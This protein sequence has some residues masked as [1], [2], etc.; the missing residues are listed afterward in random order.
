MC[1]KRSS[2][3]QLELWL[4]RSCHSSLFPRF[5]RLSKPLVTRISIY[6]MPNQLIIGLLGTRRDPGLLTAT[7][8][9]DVGYEPGCRLTS[10]KANRVTAIVLARFLGA[11][12]LLPTLINP[13]HPRRSGRSNCRRVVLRSQISLVTCGWCDLITSSRY[14][15]ESGSRIR[16][17]NEI[18]LMMR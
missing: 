4:G 8:K 16:N 7:N 1:V 17:C 6:N 10:S 14:S 12:S 11:P 18:E 2:P 13:I 3:L 5:D 9:V 15:F